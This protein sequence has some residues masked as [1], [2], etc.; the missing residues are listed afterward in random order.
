[1]KSINTLKDVNQESE[2]L[3]SMEK[4]NVMNLQRIMNNKINKIHKV[5][6]KNQQFQSKIRK[7]TVFKYN[8]FNILI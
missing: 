3:K 6:D 7:H 4:I 2:S 8:R 5:I 1:L